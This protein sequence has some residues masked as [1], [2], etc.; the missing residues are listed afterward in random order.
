MCY[1]IS[2]KKSL[3]ELSE[4]E[5]DDDDYRIGP[6]SSEDELVTS[7]SQ[8]KVCYHNAVNTITHYL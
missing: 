4:E 7:D 8:E 1:I 3:A 2:L 6:E 5:E